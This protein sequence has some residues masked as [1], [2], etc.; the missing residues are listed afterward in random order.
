M[1]PTFIDLFAGCGGLSLGLM[2]AGWKGL[3]AVEKDTQAFATLKHNL[4]DDAE[5]N[6]LSYE[7]P[8]WLPCKHISVSGLISG[9]APYLS[10]LKGKVDLI[11]GGPPCQG[12]SF[13]GKRKK[14]DPR[15]HLFRQYLKLVEIVQ[16]KILLLENVKGITVEFK[17]KSTKRK[18]RRTKAF[19]DRIKDGIEKLGYYVDAGLVKAVDFGVPQLRPRFI[20]VA[21]RKDLTDGRNV[22]VLQALSEL[23]ESF[24][25]GKGLPID[26]PVSARQAISDLERS[27]AELIPCVDSVGFQQIRYKRPKSTFQRLLH[28]TCDGSPNSMRLAKHREDVKEKFESILRTCIRGKSLSEADRKRLGLT[29][30]CIVALDP[31]KPSHTLTTLPDD[32]LHYAEPRILT[33]RECAR[34]QSFPDWYEFCGKYTTGGQRRRK[35]CPRYSQVGNAVPPLLA[36]AIGLVLRAEWV[37]MTAIFSKSAVA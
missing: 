2:R 6:G 27:G 24:L 14:S 36:E 23:R 19:S 13:A 33:V 1:A 3:F 21:I 16:P 18:R 7:W 9:Y 12:F 37:E 11:A 22:S 26:R 25:A 20:L 4:V 35:E 8:D 29:K 17:N 15:N 31:D 32:L 34:L 5:S 28:G 30:Q 10:S